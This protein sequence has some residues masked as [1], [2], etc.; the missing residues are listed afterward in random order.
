MEKALEGS[1]LF[2]QEAQ[3]AWN[4]LLGD[5][6]GQTWEKSFENT[7]D[8]ISSTIHVWK[9]KIAQWIHCLTK[10]SGNGLSVYDSRKRRLQM[11]INLSDSWKIEDLGALFPN[12]SG[13]C[14]KL[15]GQEKSYSFNVANITSEIVWR[16]DLRFRLQNAKLQTQMLFETK[17]SKKE[18]NLRTYLEIESEKE[19]IKCSW[20]EFT[21]DINT[22]SE[23]E[24][25]FWELWVDGKK[26]SELLELQEKINWFVSQMKA[27]VAVVESTGPS[28]CERNLVRLSVHVLLWAQMIPDVQNF[29][30]ALT[31]AMERSFHSSNEVK[32]AW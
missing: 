20:K 25:I 19:V 22:F 31:Q 10:L 23:F 13:F 5:F 21:E 9:P 11:H 7:L 16:N 32:V 6:F 2:S 17:K 1:N 15:K 28:T 24:A 12:Q 3:E 8:P 26:I 29:V 30:V 14:L 4:K 27:F 18:T